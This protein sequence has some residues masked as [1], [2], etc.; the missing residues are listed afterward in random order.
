PAFGGLYWRQQ[1]HGHPP[2]ASLT[3]LGGL[4]AA[5]TAPVWQSVQVAL[6][7]DLG[8]QA[9]RSDDPVPRLG[10]KLGGLALLPWAAY[11]LEAHFIF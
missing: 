6:A 11:A 7:V 10:A 4:H 3:A 5:V 1:S 8:A 9:V 2:Q